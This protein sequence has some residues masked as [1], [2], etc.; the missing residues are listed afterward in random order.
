ML[1]LA[2]SGATIAN[3]L[4]GPQDRHG[5]VIPPQLASAQRARNASVIIVNIGANDLGW[6]AMVSYCA[7]AP[8]CDD[9]ATTA[10]F[11]QQLA[12]FS[13][14][15]LQLL[16]QL[17]TLP[18]HPRVIINQYYDPFGPEQNCLGPAG[19]TPAKLTILTSRLTTLN[20]VLAKGAA[21]F[22][23]LSPQPDFTGHQLCTS[24]P[25]VQGFR[26]P[27]AVPP[28]RP[29]AARDRAHR[30]GGPAGARPSGPGT[31]VTAPPPGR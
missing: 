1:N 22:G 10:Y 16:S 8:R 2:C 21:E 13:K 5:T 31:Q 30:P 28:H 14:N 9:K 18:G 3:G 17:A 19:L 15:Y 27:G 4:L 29:R 20:A 24:Q 6:A 11:Q 12:S 25:Y 23:F 26:R 7:V